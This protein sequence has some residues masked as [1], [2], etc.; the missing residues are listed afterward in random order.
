MRSRRCS[1]SK[2][3]SREQEFRL[4]LRLGGRRSHT[5]LSP[6]GSTALK[7]S[8]AQVKTDFR[9]GEA[10][11]GLADD[12]MQCELGVLRGGD[13]PNSQSSR[14]DVKHPVTDAIVPRRLVRDLRLAC[15]PRGPANINH[16]VAASCQKQCHWLA[17]LHEKLV[18]PSTILLT[19]IFKIF[20]DNGKRRW[21]GADDAVVRYRRFGIAALYYAIFRPG[22]SSCGKPKHGGNDRYPH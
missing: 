5:E 12:R 20:A 22:C 19:R 16:S 13:Y 15:G 14:C 3:G 4:R 17:D 9:D 6:H 7:A 8:V 10:N 11:L 18:A 1:T 2:R 21:S